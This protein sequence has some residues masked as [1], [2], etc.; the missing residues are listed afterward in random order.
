MSSL[1]STPKEFVNL[2]INVRKEGFCKDKLANLTEEAALCSDCYMK[3]IQLE[4]NMSRENRRYSPEDFSSLKE[5]CGIS[6]SYP[7]T[8]TSTSQ[9]P[10]ETPSCD[11][12]YKAKAGDTPNSIAESLSV[13][14]D[15]LLVYNGFPL[16]ADL[17]FTGGEILC[18]D[19]VSKCLIHQV[20]ATETCNS[21]LKLA[22][23]GVSDLMM[24]SWNP[25][26]G[27]KCKNIHSAV[28]KYICIGPP[29]QAGKFTPTLPSAPKGPSVSTGPTSTYSWEQAPN[30]ITSSVNFT[31]SWLFPTDP[32]SISTVSA[33]IPSN[34]MIAAMRER[35]TFCPFN[36]E[37][38]STLWDEGLEEDEYHLHSWDLPYECID[39]YWDPYCFPKPA[40]PILPSPTTIPSSCYPTITTILEEWVEPPAPTQSGS[41]DNCNK[42]HIVKQG[43][44]CAAIEA[45]YKINDVKL[46]RYNPGVNEQC[47]NLRVGSAVCVRIWEGTSETSTPTATTTPAGP[48]GPT[49]SGS[50]PNC[51]KWHLRQEGET[52]ESIAAKYGIIV[53]RFRQL[54]RGVNQECS[55]LASG[56]WAIILQFAV[57]EAEYR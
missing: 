26:L 50:N 20:T 42:W 43:D 19:E 45:R 38:N 49:A 21:L 22:G 52:C 28:G 1:N 37:N 47:T 51:Q 41:P 17:S 18:L 10:L 8:R 24:R 55:N 14:T 44:T 54:N 32:P 40:D 56:N 57:S 9:V 4:I 39:E 3:S 27:Y 23:D 31:T 5:S 16:T 33:V 7:V 53:S 12:P 6:T 25:S 15:R 30:S 36:S 35:I 2:R 48:P 34:E 13:A 11:K 46:H 29:G